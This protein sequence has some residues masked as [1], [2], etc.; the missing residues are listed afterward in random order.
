[1]SGPKIGGHLEVTMEVEEIRVFS[2]F[3][4]GRMSPI[5]D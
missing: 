1:M 4:L 2:D 3:N 5:E